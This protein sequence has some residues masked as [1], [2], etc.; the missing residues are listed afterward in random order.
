MA[1][2]GVDPYANFGFRIRRGDRVVAAMSRMSARRDAS[3]GDR[4]GPITLERGVTRDP[5]FRRWIESAPRSGEGAE[6]APD[7]VPADL[8]LE[9]HDETGRL[10]ARYRVLGCRPSE[11]RAHSDL[12]AGG[13]AVAIES[14]TLRNEGWTRAPDA[15][16][17]PDAS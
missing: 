4:H 8:V 11:V 12:R 10:V 9:A 15:A 13:D 1:T 3:G 17:P 14:L 5:E 7:D 2:L 16:G 6:S